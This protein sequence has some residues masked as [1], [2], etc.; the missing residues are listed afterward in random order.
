MLNCESIID[1]TESDRQPSS[2]AG[3]LLGHAG[4]SRA[5]ACKNAAPAKLRPANAERIYI[6]PPAA[7]VFCLV[8]EPLRLARQGYTTI[9]SENVMS[10]T[11]IPF[12]RECH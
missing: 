3:L 8:C 12:L 5:E 9:R 2:K 7:E 6:V 1:A 10:H 11:S 4:P